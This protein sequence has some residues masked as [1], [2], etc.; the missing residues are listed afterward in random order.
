MTNGPSSSLS[1]LPGCSVVGHT[2]ALTR[3]VMRIM[4]SPFVFPLRSSASLLVSLR[5]FHSHFL[6]IGLPAGGSPKV[7]L[8][9]PT[10]ANL[11]TVVA[12]IVVVRA[13][14]TVGNTS[15]SLPPL[16]FRFMINLFVMP[17]EQAKY[18]RP[19]LPFP[20]PPLEASAA[21]LLHY[22]HEC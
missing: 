5:P 6:L 22:S 4:S 7:A 20:S 10:D 15:C 11:G 21:C 8:C 13:S 18:V 16:S 9:P 12:I 17:N 2:T 3:S 1:V 19:R 14:S